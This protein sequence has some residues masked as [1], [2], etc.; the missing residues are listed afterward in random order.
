MID[1][2]VQD[3]QDENL[4]MIS[5]KYLK[6]SCHMKGEHHQ[7]GRSNVG[8]DT[9]Y[10]RGLFA[11]NGRF[12]VFEKIKNFA[13]DYYYGKTKLGGKNSIIDYSPYISREEYEE[14]LKSY[15]TGVAISATFLS[16]SGGLLLGG[17]LV[18]GVHVALGDPVVLGNKYFIINGVV[19]GASIIGC[20]ISS[21]H[22]FSAIF[23]YDFINA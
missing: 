17:L 5:D 23:N 3:I 9:I 8:L 22:L 10:E 18:N 2:D 20:I 21:G 4:K 15:K 16:I 14:G 19:A 12:P 1:V 11:G 6:G 13:G 7:A